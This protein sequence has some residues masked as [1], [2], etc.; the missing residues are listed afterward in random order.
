M[1]KIK[2]DPDSDLVNEQYAIIY[3]PK[4]D[5]GQSKRR[6]RDRFPENCVVVVDS[7]AAAM[8]GFDQSTNYYPAKVVGPC[9]SSE[10]FMIYYLVNWLCDK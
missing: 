9:R 8:A 2:I 6:A 1:A 4:F 5:T 10:G 7:E 3:H